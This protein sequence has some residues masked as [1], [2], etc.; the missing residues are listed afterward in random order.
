MYPSNRHATE[1]LHGRPP[2]VE[3]GLCFAHSSG[4]IHLLT[5]PTHGQSY[6][7]PIIAS[8]VLKLSVQALHRDFDRAPI[9]GAVE[10]IRTLIRPDEVRVMGRSDMLGTELTLKEECTEFNGINHNADR[11]QSDL[12][13]IEVGECLNRP[14][15]GDCYQNLSDFPIA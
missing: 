8:S 9:A 6:T 3:G 11:K 1:C 2:I 13:R 14:Y 4:I 12:K 15:N 7:P 5:D 10:H